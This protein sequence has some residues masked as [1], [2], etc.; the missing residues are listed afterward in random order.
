MA[1]VPQTQTQ[2]QRTCPSCHATEDEIR[3]TG[4]R[5]GGRLGHEYPCP[6]AC[7]CIPEH[8]S[9]GEHR[10]ADESDVALALSDREV[11]AVGAAELEMYARVLDEEAE[12]A[13]RTA[14]ALRLGARA[15]LALTVRATEGRR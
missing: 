1:N 9:M 5:S 10:A 13:R 12:T 14:A 8:L 7:S 2:T 11:R 3:A 4:H 6:E 15:L